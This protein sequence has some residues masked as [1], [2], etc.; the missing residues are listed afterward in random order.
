MTDEIQGTAEEQSAEDDLAAT[1]A[2]AIKEGEDESAD[3]AA[4]N[5][6]D[7]E[8]EDAEKE[9]DKDTDGE[10][11]E[12]TAS[13]DDEEETADSD[14]TGDETSEDNGDEQASE[15]A[16]EP[17]AM[18]SAE[19]KE[20]FHKQS[21]EAQEFLTRRTQEMDADHTR[22][23]QE[24]AEHR[25][26]ADAFNSAVEPYG[27]YIAS[28]NTTAPEAVRVLLGT[29]YA[30]RNGTPEKKLAIMAH[31]AKTY[32]IDLDALSEQSEGEP[33]S[34]EIARL[35]Q[36]QAVLERTVQG[37][38]AQVATQIQQDT[39]AQVTVFAEEKDASGNLLRPHF[40]EVRAAMGAEIDLNPGTDMQTAYDNAVWA[41]PKLREANLASARQE[42]EQAAEHKR[43]EAD[44][45]A[46]QKRK[47]KTKAAKKAASGVKATAEPPGPGKDTAELTLVQEIEREFK[48]LSSS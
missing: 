41:N 1:I 36:R 40:V 39:E 12:E 21:R 35:E 6:K 9:S 2:A 13:S 16:I 46:E 27:A 28:L 11:S 17:P 29:E 38:R 18:F 14:D 44:K 22:K 26:T 32:G 7:V 25:K 37:E 19:D 30:L 20:M 5:G 47:E 43:S 48:A 31:F 10:H 34:P 3:E 8:A 15:P 4:S 33:I 42:A 23:T 45:K 24:I